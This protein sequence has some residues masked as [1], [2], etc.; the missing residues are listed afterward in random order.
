MHWI[1]TGVTERKALLWVVVTQW[2]GLGVVLDGWHLLA[3]AWWCLTLIVIFSCARLCSESSPVIL[4]HTRRQMLVSLLL[5]SWGNREATWPVQVTCPQSGWAQ[6]PPP[7]ASWLHRQAL[8]TRLYFPQLKGG[9][10]YRV[11][12]LRS[13]RLWEALVRQHCP[14]P[15]AWVYTLFCQSKNFCSCL[16]H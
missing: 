15:W 8:T 1:A 14:C 16:S 7:L 2:Y 6:W 9:S 5:Y 11:G 13:P 4:S 10:S 12:E 3:C